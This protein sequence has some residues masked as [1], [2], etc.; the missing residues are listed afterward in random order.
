MTARLSLL[1]LLLA[2]ATAFSQASPADGGLRL[3]MSEVELGTSREHLS[4]GRADWTSTS[5]EGVHRFAPRQ[6]LYGGL[7][8]TERFSLR[9]TEAWAGYYH[10]LARDW[11]AL[12][13]ASSSPDHR[14]LAKYSMFGQLSRQLSDGWGLSAGLRHSEYTR[15]GVN[16][17]VL[18]AERYWGDFRAGY[19]L[20]AGRPEGAQTGVAHRFTFNRYYGE[21]SSVGIAVTAGREVENVGPPTG[22]T[23]TDVRNLT[24]SGRHWMTQDW[25]LS[26]DL[27]AHEQGS[28][29]RREGFRLGLRY[30]F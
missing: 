5:L 1:V 28:L 9:D 2:P 11:T 8:E 15:S 6:T 12:V 25:A 24:V 30:R 7:R 19:N 4:G 22:I 17:L 20:Y 21:G 18:G 13:E 3:R 10:P 27:V 23:S 14:V 26:W 16:L 29:Y